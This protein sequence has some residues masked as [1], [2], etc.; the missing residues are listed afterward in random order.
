MFIFNFSFGQK[1]L[2]L[3]S[4]SKE[5]L[6]FAAYYSSNGSCSGYSDL[7]GIINYCTD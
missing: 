4:Q 5:V 2:V 3:D 1:V 7:R 6:P